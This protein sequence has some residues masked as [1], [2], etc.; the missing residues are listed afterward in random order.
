MDAAA[1]ALEE[2]GTGAAMQTVSRRRG[3]GRAAAGLCVG[4]AASTV[5]GPARL[6]LSRRECMFSWAA[7]GGL[8]GAGG[9]GI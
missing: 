9:V 1:A 7:S 3:A 8:G 2:G 4:R 5:L 6:W